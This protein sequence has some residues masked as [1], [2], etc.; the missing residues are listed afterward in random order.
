M[1]VAEDRK[2]RPAEDIRE[3]A[4]YPVIKQ[5]TQPNSD[6]EDCWVKKRNKMIYGY[7]KHVATGEA[8]MILAAHTRPANAH[9]SKG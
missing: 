7:K 3:E 6:H 1:V 9:D 8:G 4:V 2:E 5:Q